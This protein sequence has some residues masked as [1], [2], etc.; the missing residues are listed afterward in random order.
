MGGPCVVEMRV[1]FQWVVWKLNILVIWNS[2]RR[3]LKASIGREGYSFIDVGI[4]IV[5]EYILGSIGRRIGHGSLIAC[6]CVCCFVRFFWNQ[7]TSV[8]F[9]ALPRGKYRL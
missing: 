9:D 4:R 5:S 7:R 2:N 3:R 8:I 1:F 6:C